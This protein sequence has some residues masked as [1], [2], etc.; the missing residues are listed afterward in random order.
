MPTPTDASWYA[1]FSDPAYYCG[2]FG[3]RPGPDGRGYRDFE[4][5]NTIWAEY[6]ALKRPTSVLDLGCGWGYLVQKLRQRGIDAWGIDISSVAMERA[7]DAVKPY[8]C[9]G[10]S[11]DLACL[12][13]HFP[14]H[15]DM[16]VSFGSLEHFTP[17]DVERVCRE[18]PR[19]SQR[20]IHAIGLSTEWSNHIPLAERDKTHCTMQ[21]YAWWRSKLPEPFEIWEGSQETWDPVTGSRLKVLVVAPSALPVGASGYGGIERLA[22]LL[23]RELARRALEISLAAPSGSRAPW[24][25]K[26]IDT[27]PASPPDFVSQ[28]YRAYTMLAP[29]VRSYNAILDLSHSHWAGRLLPWHTRSLNIIWHAPD[30]MQP[31]EPQWN[32]AALSQWQADMFLAYQRQRARVLDVHVLDDYVPTDGQVGDRFLAVSKINQ[33]KGILEAIR[34]CQRLGVGLDIV[35]PLGE[36]PQYNQ[37]VLAGCQGKIAYLGELPHRSVLELASRAVAL[38]YPSNEPEAHSHKSVDALGAGCPVITWRRYAYPEVVEH[39]VDGFLADDD[40]QFEGAMR[41]AYSL[42]RVEIARRALRRW[43]ARAVGDRLVPVLVDVSRGARW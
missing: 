6:I 10:N 7:P 33:R 25:V 1:Q 15:F 41:M 11:A 2:D 16:T 30:V 36:D 8:L 43:G 34:F 13:G 29:E 4:P 40:E 18:I 22:F 14:G 37:A 3:Y 38:L 20:G 19:V 5:V 9:Q 12:P 39:G 17:E 21:N 24:G 26:L 28:E 42:D 35:G 27:G 32:V 31:P 23:S